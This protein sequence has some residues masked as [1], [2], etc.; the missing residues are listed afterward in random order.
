MR[1]RM[2]WN[3]NVVKIGGSAFDRGPEV[4][5]LLADEIKKLSKEYKFILTVGG[6]DP[7]IWYRKFNSYLPGVPPSSYVLTL[8]SEILRRFLEKRNCKSKVI[9]SYDSENIR[10]SLLGGYL[11]IVPYINIESLRIANNEKFP[12]DEADVFTLLIAEEFTAE[13]CIFIKDAYGFCSNDPNAP[14]YKD[15]RPVILDSPYKLDE[16]IKD[17]TKLYLYRN[18]GISEAKKL[19]NNDHLVAKACISL[20][21]KAHNVQYI[22][23]IDAKAPEQLKK[24]LSGVEVGTKFYKE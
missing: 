2:N 5:S 6:G 11:P 24:L 9:S 13:K 8:N 20:F 12:P 16:E 10:S 4:I 7:L 22:Y 19:I 17:T 1:H 18:I 14:V 3:I 21:Q 23:I 15:L